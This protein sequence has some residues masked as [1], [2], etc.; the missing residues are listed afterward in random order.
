MC[1]STKHLPSY[2][3]RLWTV[4]DLAKNLA[5]GGKENPHS[6]LIWIN[7]FIICFQ[8]L[9]VIVWQLDF[10]PSV[11]LHI[12]VLQIKYLRLGLIKVLI[13]RA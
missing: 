1:T 3:L 6:K 7:S 9:F 10:K 2:F 11:Y 12:D 4:H 13:L 5:V 8:D